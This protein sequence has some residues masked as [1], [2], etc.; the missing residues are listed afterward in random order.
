MW[1]GVHVTDATELQQIARLVELNRQQLTSLGEQI[2]R[3]STAL[4][5]HREIIT[6]LSSI[7][8]DESN[9]LMVPLGSGIQLLVDQLTNPGVVI[10]IG[11]G[12]QAERPVSEAIELL[13]KR[14]L[15]IQELISTLQSE[16]DEIEDKVKQLASKF[17]EGAEVL[18][19]IEEEQIDEVNDSKEQQPSSKKRKGNISGELTLDD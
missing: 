11:S 3:L 2:E 15:E 12:I 6:A 7:S 17:T 10:D 1:V 5:E 18:Q 9:R 19:S 8:T 16:F 4:L 13:E 14:Y